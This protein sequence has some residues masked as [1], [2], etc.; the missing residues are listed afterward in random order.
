MTVLVFRDRGY[1]VAT[2]AWSVAA[3]PGKG[4]RIV[5]VWG[6][7]Q[8]SFFQGATGDA[9]CDLPFYFDDFIKRIKDKAFVDLRSDQDKR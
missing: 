9:A 2:A 7:D 1:D 5:Y 3:K 8:I 6:A 4:V